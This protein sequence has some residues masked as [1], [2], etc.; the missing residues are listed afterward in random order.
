MTE[1]LSSKVAVI[2]DEAP[3][4]A[5]PGPSAAI[6]GIVG[7]AE[8]GPIGE[9]TLCTSFEA[10][11]KT[12]GGFMRNSDLAQNV[13]GFFRNGGRQLYVVRVVH[14][15]DVTDRTSVTARAAEAH[16]LGSRNAAAKV[17]AKDLGTVGNKLRLELVNAS[18]GDLELTV[19]Q[20]QRLLEHWNAESLPVL[21]KVVSAKSRHVEIEP[22]A[23]AETP[24]PQTNLLAG[25]DAG[26]AGISD[27]DFIGDASAKT[28]MRAL[29]K[30][31]DLSLLCIPGASANVDREM[32]DYCTG[33]RRGRVFPVLDMP[34]GIGAEAAKA[35]VEREKLLGSNENGAIYWPR[36]RITNP[37]P[38]IWP[39][40]DLTT[41]PAG[42]V[43]GVI[44]RNTSASPGGVYVPPAGVE[45]G[46]LY[47]VVGYDHDDCLDEG[48]RDVVY[49]S[50]I[51]PLTT[52]E[53]LPF[54]IDGS[55]TL[56]V[57]GNCPW[58]AH[59]RGMSFIERNLERRLQYTR[60]KPITG[61]LL[62]AV[63]RD[64]TTYLIE[65]MRDGAFATQDPRT[66]FHVE[67]PSASRSATIEVAV[68]L[69]FAEPAEFIWLHMSVQSNG[70]TTKGVP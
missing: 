14:Y 27:R 8:R 10:Y 47:G 70:G 65:Q 68:G 37:A 12:F 54:F 11:Q 35:Y 63:Y 60:H 5:L 36:L 13:W 46:Q 23:D 22:I 2:E 69:A 57:T 15:A 9:A 59:R 67:A 51:N 28:G 66:A 55:R 42:F 16:V 62:A 64:I 18:N 25:G 40:Q 49:P 30:V 43:C 39:G 29:D 34:A 3:L 20:G 26:T 44:A 53:G 45:A 52:M 48:M 56:K 32:I 50:R 24:I 17:R 19:V 7:I 33:P 6:T 21:A 31:L 4:R 61:A 58:V 41:S 38:E 1:F